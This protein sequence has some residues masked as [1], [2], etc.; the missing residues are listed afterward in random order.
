MAVGRAAFVVTCIITMHNTLQYCLVQHVLHKVI[1][2]ITV[3]LGISLKIRGNRSMITD[4]CA[5]SNY[6][7]LRIGK[8]LGFRK[9]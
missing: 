7:T 1:I 8:A 6:Y 4:V 2:L 9:L 5:K 3:Y